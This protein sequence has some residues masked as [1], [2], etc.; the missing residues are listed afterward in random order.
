MDDDFDFEAEGPEEEDFTITPCGSLGGQTCASQA[1]GK[2]IG[3]FKT[4]SA[5]LRA[6]CKM[7]KEQQ[8]F[9]N[10]WHISDHGNATLIDPGCNRRRSRKR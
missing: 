6:I 9:P 2:F 10:V 1:G 8:F 4:D 7:M 5:A 3:Q